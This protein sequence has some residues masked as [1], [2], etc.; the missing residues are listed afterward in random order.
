[1]SSRPSIHSRP[2][3]DI[4]GVVADMLGSQPSEVLS[5]KPQEAK[6]EKPLEVKNS[7]PKKVKISKPPAVET[8]TREKTSF[9]LLP[10]VKRHLTLLKL[11]LRSGGH[12]VTEAEI[13]EALVSMASTSSVLNALRRRNAP[14]G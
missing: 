8:S 1:M 13:V 9:A 3:R 10:S 4:T 7:K 2:T 5:E 6:I 12:R 14:P 11:D